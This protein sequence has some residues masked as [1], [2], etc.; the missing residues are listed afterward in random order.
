[1]NLQR[2]S[3]FY[4]S[5]LESKRAALRAAIALA[6]GL[7]EDIAQL[8]D[9]ENRQY[10]TDALIKFKEAVIDANK[11]SKTSQDLRCALREL[12]PLNAVMPDAQSRAYAHF[13]R[14]L[15]WYDASEYSKQR[16]D[17]GWVIT[18]QVLF[19]GAIASAVILLAILG[20]HGLFAVTLAPSFLLTFFTSFQTSDQVASIAKS[21]RGVI[22]D[23]VAL[24]VEE[25]QE[26]LYPAL[27]VCYVYHSSGQP[28]PS[29]PLMCH[30][31]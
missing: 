21:G 23:R 15:N 11:M 4:G 8:R 25:L 31:K 10:C 26:A 12:L 17:Q 3:M 28:Q 22:A 13:E 1:M 19:T 30:T 20:P 18:N 5:L 16:W 29:A 24:H 7:D 14:A 6:N 9:E 2:G 27:P